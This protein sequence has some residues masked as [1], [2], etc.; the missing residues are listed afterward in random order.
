MDHRTTE[1]YE[2]MWRMIFD[3]VPN[4]KKNV[5]RISMDCERAAANAALT[6][7]DDVKIE[8]CQF[9]VKHVRKFLELQK[10]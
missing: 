5:A 7:F 3:L 8:L 10:F 6:A 4:L 2:T 1:T 9:H